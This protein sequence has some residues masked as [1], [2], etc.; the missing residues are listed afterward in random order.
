L[1]YW[2]ITHSQKEVMFLG[3]LEEILET[4]NMV[5]FQKVMV[6]LFWR[7]GYCISSLH[8]QVILHRNHLVK[9]IHIIWIDSPIIPMLVLLLEKLI[10]ALKSIVDWCFKFVLYICFYSHILI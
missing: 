2:P 7:I 3:E 6:P 4:I 8:F 1:K 5:E 10:H 9:T